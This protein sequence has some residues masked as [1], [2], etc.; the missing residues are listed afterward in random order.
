MSGYDE[1]QR[2]MAEINYKIRS[3]DNNTSYNSV[4]PGFEEIFKGF[5]K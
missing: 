2:I 3:K 5:R 1:F 4:P